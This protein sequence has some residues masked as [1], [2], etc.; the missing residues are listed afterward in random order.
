MEIKQELCK[1]HDMQLIEA[2]H[3]VTDIIIKSFT[4]KIPFTSWRMGAFNDVISESYCNECFRTQGQDD[5][6]AGIDYERSR[7][8][9]CTF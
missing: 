2:N 5:F 4:F 3:N 6:Y 7:N 1:K 9:E 8:N